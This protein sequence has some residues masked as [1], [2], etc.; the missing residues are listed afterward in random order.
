MGGKNNSVIMAPEDIS[1]TELEQE[2]QIARLAPVLGCQL[3]T[4][5]QTWLHPQPR[6]QVLDTGWGWIRRTLEGGE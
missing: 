5:N 2:L 1:Q 4:F 6:P 3:E